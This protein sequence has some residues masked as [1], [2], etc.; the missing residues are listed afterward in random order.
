M[1]ENLFKEIPEV[2][3][4]LPKLYEHDLSD[5]TNDEDIKPD[6]DTEPPAPIVKKELL[7]PS[8][9]GVDSWGRRRDQDPDL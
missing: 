7:W 8:S 6:D 4:T 5:L 3:Y 9:S 2:F 1:A